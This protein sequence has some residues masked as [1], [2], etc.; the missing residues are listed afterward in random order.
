[1][2][3]YLYIHGNQFSTKVSI[4]LL[5]I[6]LQLGFGALNNDSEEYVEREPPIEIIQEA[7]VCQILIFSYG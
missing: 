2:Y 6:I 7:Q 4:I 1:M 3:I 5:V